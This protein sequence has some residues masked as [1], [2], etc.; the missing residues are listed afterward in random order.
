MP[1]ITELRGFELSTIELSQMVDWPQSLIEDY[2]SLHETVLELIDAIV[3][4]AA[5]T[6]PPA[7]AASPGTAG[8]TALDNDYFYVCISADTWKRSPLATW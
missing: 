3:T 5:V 2:R 4:G 1:N 7:T 6:T 8:Q